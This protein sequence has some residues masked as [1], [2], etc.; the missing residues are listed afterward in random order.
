IAET[1]VY[2]FAPQKNMGSDGGLWVAILSPRA[3]ARAQE[4]KDSGRWIPTSLD[5]VT[6]IEN[7]RKDQT[8]NTP[9]VATLL[10]LAEQ[11]ERSEESGGLAW[12]AERARTSSR[13]V[14]AWADAAEAAR[15]AVV[16][17]AAGSPALASSGFDQAGD[18]VPVTR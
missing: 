13:H 11:I 18:A 10:L 2:Y 14:F 4:I 16:E 17:P 8:Y 6:A 7:S 15:P 9:A 5:L 3:I 12:A 1:D